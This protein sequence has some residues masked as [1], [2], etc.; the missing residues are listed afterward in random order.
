MKSKRAIFTVWLL[1]IITIL[2]AQTFQD[3]PGN[4][5]E[6]D[7]PSKWDLVKGSAQIG[8]LEGAKVILFDRSSIIMPKNREH[9]LLIRQFYFKV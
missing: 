6:G 5:N 7:F 2:G 1:F 4:E 8:S 3:G 9:R